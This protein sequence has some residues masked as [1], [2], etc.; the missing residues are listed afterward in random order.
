MPIGGRTVS[1]NTFNIPPGNSASVQGTLAAASACASDLYPPAPVAA[2]VYPPLLGGA[3]GNG[4]RT[5]VDQIFLCNTDTAAR[6]V[7]IDKNTP[8]T[9]TTLAVA[10]GR[11]SNSL[12]KAIPLATGET[13]VIPGP[14]SLYNGQVLNIFASS[15][16]V[17][18][19]IVEFRN[20]P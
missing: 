12:F 6:T 8:A 4:K 15:A 2:S 14:I 7:T 1:S 9:A 20:E 17:V 13:I 11:A 18:N 5:T 3:Y 16:S 10:D 19:A